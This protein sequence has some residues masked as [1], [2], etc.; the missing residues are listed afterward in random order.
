MVKET[1]N[2]TRQSCCPEIT[3]FVQ[4]S[5][6]VDLLP[7]PPDKLVDASQKTKVLQRE[8]LEYLN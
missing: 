7:N 6:S 8:D 1:D 2:A 4:N 5:S 3:D